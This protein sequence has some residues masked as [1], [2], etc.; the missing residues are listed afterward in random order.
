MELDG[1][2]VV[3]VMAAN[4]ALRTR[5]RNRKE[6][7]EKGLAGGPASRSFNRE[8]PA[9]GNRAAVW[10]NAVRIIAGLEHAV[11]G[12]DDHE[13]VASERLGDRTN[14]PRKPELGSYLTIGDG[15]AIRNGARK[16]IDPLVEGGDARHV[17]RHPRKIGRLA[18]QQ[19][20]DAFYRGFN[21]CGRADFAG[22]GIE[23]EQALA[24]LDL[25][26]QRKLHT[27]D[28]GTAPCDAA[29]ANAAIENGILTR[30]HHVTRPKAPYQLHTRP[31]LKVIGGADLRPRRQRRALERG[32]SKSYKIEG[33]GGNH[34]HVFDGNHLSL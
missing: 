21:T 18:A 29:S 1:L 11:T 5:R 13:G 8:Q 19:R 6:Y 31:H 25:A 33:A 28:A 34:H 7:L 32:I 20:D 10:G 2:S 27:D 22:A 26:S 9:L 16:T 17:E 30:R 24:G 14:G 12:N 4:L 23:R 3:A 15:L